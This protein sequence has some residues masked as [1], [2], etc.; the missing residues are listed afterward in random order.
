[1]GQTWVAEVYVVV[2]ASRYE[3]FPFGIDNVVGTETLSVG[4][5]DDGCYAIIFDEY[6]T[7]VLLAFVDD[8]GLV[9]QGGHGVFF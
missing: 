2:N 6:A 1:M 7:Y 8:G 5:A 3:V 9:Y 4:A